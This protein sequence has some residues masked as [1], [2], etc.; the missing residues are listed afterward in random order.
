MQDAFQNWLDRLG[1]ATGTVNTQLSRVKMVEKAYGDLDQLY[2]NDG[3]DAVRDE[4]T[5][6]TG[7]A[8]R[9]Q[10]NQSQMPIG[11]GA[12]I[13]SNLNSYKTAIA[14]YCQFRREVSGGS[15]EP[16]T[17]DLTAE[18]RSTD[19]EE[20]GQIIGLERDMQ[21]A[22]RETID[23]LEPGM[24]VIDGGAERHVSSGFI[25]I[26]AQ[27]ANGETVVIELKTG[28]ARREAVAQILCY[29]G[30]L[31]EEEP[32]AKV[33]GILIA[34][35]FDSKARAAARMVP[36]LSLQAYR[37][38]FRFTKADEISDGGVDSR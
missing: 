36:T 9:N 18:A 25:D 29:M 34:G 15:F 30:D 26:T 1:L 4:L 3:L 7:D 31:V 27:D 24:Q 13:K 33:R 37:V 2:D 8:L 6:S 14:K 38:N 32:N 22:L 12:D 23:Q 19:A 17:S 16:D 21:K 35:D 11:E 20:R 28:T 10:P 5:Y